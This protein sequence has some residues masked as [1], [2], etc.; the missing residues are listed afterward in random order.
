MI[1]SIT[2][3]REQFDLEAFYDAYK[4]FYREWAGS[5]ADPDHSLPVMEQFGAEPR[6]LYEDRDPLDELTNRQWMLFF[7]LHEPVLEKTVLCVDGIRRPSDQ[8][9][10]GIADNYGFLVEVHDGQVSLHPALYDVLSNPIPSIDLQGRCSV[11][12]QCLKEFA[13]RFITRN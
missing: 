3:E 13:H 9:D 11:M 10:I 7:P 2:I 6:T 5:A 1:E 8:F 12:D 4:A